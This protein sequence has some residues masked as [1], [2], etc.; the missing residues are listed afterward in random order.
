MSLYLSEKEHT[1]RSRTRADQAPITRARAH[2][3]LAGSLYMMLCGGAVVFPRT[4]RQRRLF[5]SL[6][7]LAWPG[8]DEIEREGKER[9]REVC[10]Q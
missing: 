10:N 8:Q 5:L 9:I 6:T 2:T 4:K 1:M 3:P 7:P